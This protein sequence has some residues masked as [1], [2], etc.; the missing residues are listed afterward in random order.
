M[1]TSLRKGD[2]HES[3]RGI[4]LIAS[5]GV[6]VL[7]ELAAFFSLILLTRWTNNIITD[8]RVLNHLVPHSVRLQVYPSTYLML[9]TSPTFEG[10]RV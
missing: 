5:P 2:D 9:S 6:L 4:S 3:L 1:C 7:S 8:F 10:R